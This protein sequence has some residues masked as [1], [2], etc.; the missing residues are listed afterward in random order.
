MSFRT[1]QNI[2]PNEPWGRITA[3]ILQWVRNGKL[4]CVGEVTLTAGTSTTITDPLIGPDS[5]VIPVAKGA[6]AEAL[7]GIGVDNYATGSCVMHHSAA[8]GTEVFRYCVI[9]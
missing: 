1:F 8:A 6:A 2:T 9:G 7:T 5:T 4:N 3:V